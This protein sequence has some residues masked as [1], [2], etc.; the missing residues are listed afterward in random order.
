MSGLKYFPTGCN[1]N[2]SVNNQTVYNRP[3]VNA[4]INDYASCEH[5]LTFLNK[6]LLRLNRRKREMFPSSLLLLLVA[7]PVFPRGYAKY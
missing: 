5:R 2:T 1:V 3:R 7:D 4:N 6:G